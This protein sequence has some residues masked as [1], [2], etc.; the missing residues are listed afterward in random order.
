MS[1][2]LNREGR[3]ERQSVFIGAGTPEGEYIRP[4]LKLERISKLGHVGEELAAE[5]L[6]HHGFTD[7][8]KF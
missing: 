8:E 6:Q 7:I 5:R 1:I 3:N 4:L 2:Y